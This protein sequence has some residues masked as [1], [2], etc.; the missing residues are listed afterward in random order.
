MVMILRVCMC[1]NYPIRLLLYCM[2]LSDNRACC[3]I[4]VLSKNNVPIVANCIR[5]PHC[6][7]Q[8]SMSSSVLLHETVRLQSFLTKQSI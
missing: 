3:L 2:G 4:S 7:M 8:L 5:L 6:H 1:H